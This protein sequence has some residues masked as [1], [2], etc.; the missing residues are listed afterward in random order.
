M[1]VWIPWLPY[2]SANKYFTCFVRLGASCCWADGAASHV[3]LA[4][5]PLQVV[6]MKSSSTASSAPWTGTVCWDRRQNLFPS[7]SRRTTQVI[8]IVCALP[9]I[10]WPLLDLKTFHLQLCVSDLT[11]TNS[12]K[13]SA[14]VL[15]TVRVK[16]SPLKT[17]TLLVTQ[18]VPKPSSTARSEKYHHMETEEEDD[19]NDED[20]TVEIRQFSSC[21]HRFSKVSEAWQE[22][23]RISV[24]ATQLSWDSLW[25]H[26]P[27]VGG[28]VSGT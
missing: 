6:P 21:S 7:W 15:Q 3:C 12:R 14:A 2:F 1:G 20:F 22:S 23:G 13:H 17:E 9:D 10:P 11:P 27:F 24:A 8:L 19:T 26:L 18:T 5:L 16:L 4:L 25:K 28:E